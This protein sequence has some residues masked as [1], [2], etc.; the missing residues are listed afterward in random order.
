MSL[1]ANVPLCIHHDSYVRHP[2]PRISHFLSTLLVFPTIFFSL[3][4]N[5]CPINENKDG[6]STSLDRSRF[7]L[8]PFASLPFVSFFFF[9]FFF[10]FRLH[11]ARERDSFLPAAI[12]HPSCHTIFSSSPRSDRN[13][14]ACNY[15]VIY[16]H[17]RMHEY[18][19]SLA[20]G[21]FTIF[22]F[23]PSSPL[24]RPP[25][26]FLFSSCCYHICATNYSSTI[27]RATE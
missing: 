11:L 24:P 16:A 23:L 22:P 26:F 2:L 20:S 1:Y 25:C 4:T 21:L 17:L 7:Q 10:L 3:A 27:E 5:N 6:C 19:E 12:Q 13:R 8:H 14:Q 15:I 18:I 9:F